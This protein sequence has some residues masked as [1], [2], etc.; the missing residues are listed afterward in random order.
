MRGGEQ[1]VSQDGRVRAIFFDFGGVVAR[2]DR[3]LLARF[4]DR[5]GLPKGSFIKALYT[6]PEWRA[7]E[8]GE[9]TEEA[10]VTAVRRKLDELAGRTLPDIRQEW[11][12][13]WR[14]LDDDVLE[15]VRRLR[16]RYG[17]GLLSN[18]TDR[19]GSELRDY[20][21][22]DGLFRVIINSSQ[23]G[24]AKPDPRIYQLAAERMGVPPEGCVHIDDLEH[25]VEGARQAGFYGIHHRGDYPALERALRSL[26]VEW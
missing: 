3:E 19:L 16:E 8:L 26:G 23:V 24:V 15:L 18:A 7:A 10:W 17:V 25:N 9:A 12:A 21:K 14:T 2:M 11:S 22:I 6:I 1:S 20:H 13:L 5:L 4:E